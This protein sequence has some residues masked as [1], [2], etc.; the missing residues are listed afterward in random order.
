[1]GHRLD[2]EEF[3]LERTIVELVR[4]DSCIA[5]MVSCICGKETCGGQWKF[6]S[7]CFH[8][9]MLYSS[10]ENRVLI[11]RHCSLSVR[12]IIISTLCLLLKQCVYNRWCKYDSSGEKHS[13][14]T[15]ARITCM[16]LR[17][18][19]KGATTNY[20]STV[21]GPELSVRTIASIV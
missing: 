6:D 11:N 13:I 10:T 20:S 21:I 5:T 8:L 17:V 15:F 1:M 14:E 3:I 18:E 16:G 19:S 9:W 4:C 7:A 2:V 12:F